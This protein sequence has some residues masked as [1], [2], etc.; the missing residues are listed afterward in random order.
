MAIIPQKYY[1]NSFFFFTFITCPPLLSFFWGGFRALEMSQHVTTDWFLDCFLHA[2]ARFKLGSG[3][4]GGVTNVKDWIIPDE[5]L[6]G[7]WK[8]RSQFRNLWK[9]QF[10]WFFSFTPGNL[11]DWDV[12]TAFWC[13]RL[14]AKWHPQPCTRLFWSLSSR[15]RRGALIRAQGF[16]PPS[17]HII[18][19]SSR[20]RFLLLS[21]S[22]WFAALSRPSLCVKQMTALGDSYIT[23][24]WAIDPLPLTHTHTICRCF[25]L[26]ESFLILWQL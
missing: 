26:F 5:E 12:A 4:Q 1:R 9:V 17:R 25:F 10:H 8:C 24:C 20:W 19:L 23:L 16:F 11:F 7:I 14:P 3:R 18:W 13:S 15:W 22:P 2:R 21:A 6:S